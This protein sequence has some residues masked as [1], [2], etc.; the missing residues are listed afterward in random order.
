MRE[1]DISY[2]GVLCII[3]AGVF[4]VYRD[5][6]TIY[7]STGHGL[8]TKVRFGDACMNLLVGR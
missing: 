4:G 5:F 1:Y 3:L 7:V 2:I 6:W 8:L